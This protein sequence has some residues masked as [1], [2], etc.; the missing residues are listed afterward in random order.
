MTSFLEPYSVRTPLR[1]AETHQHIANKPRKC[2]NPL[3]QIFHDLSL[4]HSPQFCDTVSLK[5]ESGGLLS[6]AFGISTGADSE[7]DGAKQ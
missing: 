5:F 7:I 6:T 1:N 3:L 2:Q 4:V